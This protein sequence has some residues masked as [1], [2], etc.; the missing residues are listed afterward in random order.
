MSLFEY[1]PRKS[2]YLWLWTFLA[3]VSVSFIALGLIVLIQKFIP[4]P[5]LIN[6]R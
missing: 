3:I 4:T 6:V 2:K 1:L 5:P